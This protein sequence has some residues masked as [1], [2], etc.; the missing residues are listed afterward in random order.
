[1]IE[2]SPVVLLTDFGSIDWYA[3]TLHG[4]INKINKQIVIIDLC[5]N[6]GPGDISAGAFQLLC[7]YRYFRPGTV[8]CCVVDPGVGTDRRAI[9]AGDGTYIFVAPDNGILSW[10]QRKSPQWQAV[11]AD[12]KDLML[13]SISS[14]FQGRDVFA[15]L[16]AHLACGAALHDLGRPI[17]TMKLLDVSEIELTGPGSASGSVV[18][19]DRFG[20]LITNVRISPKDERN[21]KVESNKKNWMLE[22]QSR[23]IHGLSETFA[24]ARP[25]EL[26]FYAGS[27]GFIEIAV[28]MGH[29]GHALDAKVGTKISITAAEKYGQNTD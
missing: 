5:H 7:S 10:V 13:E 29:A 14:T 27:S 15:P 9:C 6:I 17:E 11:E 28:N 1:M 26:L 24:S 21:G 19:I 18:Y 22:I 2:P 16:A 20:N 23:K 12:R 4:I 8:F 25:G 3:G